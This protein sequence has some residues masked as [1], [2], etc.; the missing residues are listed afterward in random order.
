[1]NKDSKNSLIICQWCGQ[2]TSI[3]WV[4]GH[5]QCAICRINIDECCRGEQCETNNQSNKEQ[6][7]K[8]L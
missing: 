3:I 7:S 2:P 6:R 5:G 8:K 1:M 4:H